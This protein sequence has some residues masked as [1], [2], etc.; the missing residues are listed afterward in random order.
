MFLTN[1]CCR[2][3]NIHPP[4]GPDSLRGPGVSTTP[5]SAASNTWSYAAVS[6]S[7]APGVR[8]ASCQRLRR[9]PLRPFG[10]DSPDPLPGLS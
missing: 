6:R 3:G 8:G 5:P 10:C 7:M 1:G 4:N 2:S 9:P